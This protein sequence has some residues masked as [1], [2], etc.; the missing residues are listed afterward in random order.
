MASQSTFIGKFGCD[1]PPPL[2]SVTASQF[3]DTILLD[4]FEIFTMAWLA[5]AILAPSKDVRCSCTRVCVGH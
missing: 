2:R 4:F 1:P 3:W 5:F